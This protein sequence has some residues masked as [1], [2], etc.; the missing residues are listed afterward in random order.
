M[1][2]DAI[3]A[4][5]HGSCDTHGPDFADQDSLACLD[6]RLEL[7][8][9][10]ADYALVTLHLASYCTLERGIKSS[11]FRAIEFATGSISERV[12]NRVATCGHSSQLSLKD[13]ELALEEL[14][15]V[16]LAPVW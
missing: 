9:E 2:M 5:K 15:M 6:S 12:M 1:C 16:Q 3:A 11:C 14:S 10:V 4:L 8:P 7:Q 13:R